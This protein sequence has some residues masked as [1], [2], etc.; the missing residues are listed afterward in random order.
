V[1]RALI[2]A[3]LALAATPALAACGGSDEDA[4][5]KDFRGVNGRIAALGKDVGKT[6][7]EAS[8]KKDTQIE[9]EFGELAQSTGELAQDVDELEPPDK[10]TATKDDL[11]ESLGD[12]KDALSDIEQAA[13]KHDAQA[14]RKATIQLVASSDD[15]RDAR[16]K[17]E[18]A[19]R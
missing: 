8:G 14:A 12:A 6:V 17:L 5:K 1:S 9:D 16:V 13:A 18:R 7:N 2:A 11:V 10:L 4:F 19:T 15:L 3:V